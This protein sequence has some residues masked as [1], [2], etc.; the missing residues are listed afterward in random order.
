MCLKEDRTN[1]GL[2]K[3]ARGTGAHTLASPARL[4]SHRI[5]LQTN[6]AFLGQVVPVIARLPHELPEVQEQLEQ[7]PKQVKHVQ[8]QLEQ[9]LAEQQQGTGRGQLSPPGCQGGYLTGSRQ[10]YWQYMRSDAKPLLM[11]VLESQEQVYAVFSLKSR[12]Q[13]IQDRG[14]NGLRWTFSFAPV[15]SNSSGNHTSGPGD[16]A[17]GHDGSSGSHPTPSAATSSA[18]GASPHS[19]EVVAA[20]SEGRSPHGHSLVVRAPVPQ[21]IAEAWPRDK[22]MYVTIVGTSARCAQR[23]LLCGAILR[24]VCEALTPAA[25]ETCV[26]SY[27]ITNGANLSCQTYCQDPRLSID[28]QLEHHLQ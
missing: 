25:P 14:W 3:P 9:A 24:C 4:P 28:P 22:R 8:Q 2:D 27:M 13:H 21:K 1:I 11:D 5:A 10:E 6:P 15:S 7:L 16:G 20:D 12:G 26:Q 17:G 23:M 18:T 19:V